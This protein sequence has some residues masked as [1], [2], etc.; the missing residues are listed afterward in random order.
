MEKNDLL[1]VIVAVVCI[2]GIAISLLV[3]FNVIFLNQKI[4][5]TERTYVNGSYCV[6]SDM[7]CPEKVDFYGEKMMLIHR[8]VDEN[9]TLHCF[10][11]FEIRYNFNGLPVKIGG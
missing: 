8:F 9:C 4:E 5:N 1:F 11:G 7:K 3:L 10:Y 6:N 2:I